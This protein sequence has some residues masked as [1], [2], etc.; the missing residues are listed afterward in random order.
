MLH[1]KGASFGQAAALP[2][3][4]IPDWKGLPRTNTQAYYEN[5]EITAVESIIGLAPRV[6]G[7]NPFLFFVL[8]RMK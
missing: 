6:L 8:E 1:L 4:I 5:L 2:A 7:Y 3:N